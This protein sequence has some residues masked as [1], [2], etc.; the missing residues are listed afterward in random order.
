MKQI[1]ALKLINW[2]KISNETILFP[3]NM[4][5]T[6][7]NG[8]GKS[9]IIDALSIV[10]T[11][12]PK[13]FNL[14]ANKND[15]RNINSYVRCYT[16]GENYHSALR[17]NGRI[18]SHIALEFKNAD[19][20]LSVTGVI[21]TSESNS[22]NEKIEPKWYYC[23]NCSLSD[24]EFLKNGIPQDHRSL[25]AK[26]NVVKTM[27]TQKNA[28]RVFAKAYGFSG[29]VDEFNVE[30]FT[31]F[32]SILKNVIAAN[33]HNFKNVGDIISNCVLKPKNID[34]EEERKNYD[35]INE[36]K[37]RLD[38][39]EKKLNDLGEMEELHNKIE[40]YS[41]E[42][43]NYENAKIITQCN[44]NKNEIIKNKNNIKINEDKKC[45]YEKRFEI[46]E[47]EIESL[48]KR[49]EE[50]VARGKDSIIDNLKNQISSITEKIN[51]YKKE[52][53]KIDKSLEVFKMLCEAINESSFTKI[54]N[55]YL[56]D[57][58]S[59]NAESSSK[60]KEEIHK[61]ILNIKNLRNSIIKKTI[62]SKNV[63]AEIN[64][65]IRNCEIALSALRV[66]QNPYT[67]KVK[68]IQKFL[69]KE[70][71]SKGIND[72][73]QILCEVMDFTENSDAWI[74][75]IEGFMGNKRFA[76][77]CSPKNFSVVNNLYRQLCKENVS[78]KNSGIE[79][80]DMRQFVYDE[81]KEFGENMMIGHLITPN[82][83]V[84]RYLQYA[85]GNVELVEDFRN[86]KKGSRAI[87]KDCMRYVG[88]AT[89]YINTNNYKHKY[90]GNKSRQ[91]EIKKYTEELTCLKTEKNNIMSDIS[92]LNNISQYFDDHDLSDMV[93]CF[94]SN[95]SD[96]IDLIV[97]NKENNQ[98][99]V[100]LN[101]SLNEREKAL[102]I[103]SLA[104]EQREIEENIRKSTKEKD[105]ISNKI[106]NIDSKIENF[107]DIV[108]KLEE[109]QKEYDKSLMILEEE[110]YDAY[111]GAV[112]L[113]EEKY[114]HI[115]NIAEI[116][117]SITDKITR[118]DKN[119][120]NLNGRLMSKQN[121]FVEK[122]DVAF[123]TS[124]NS[125]SQQYI[126]YY[127]NIKNGKLIELNEKLSSAQETFKNN[128]YKNVLSCL[129]ESFI[130]VPTF[131]KRMNINL[132]YSSSE[133]ATI[134]KFVC[135]KTTD[136]EKREIYDLIM[137]CDLS[138]IE[139]LDECEKDVIDNLIKNLVNAGNED[140]LNDFADYRNYFE[141][142]VEIIKNGTTKR[143]SATCRTSSG[144][145]LKVPYY[146]IMGAALSN[147]YSSFDAENCIR[148][149]IA[150]EAFSTMDEAKTL[151]VIQILK[152][153]G[154]QTIFAAPLDSNVATKIGRH[155]N[156]IIATVDKPEYRYTH[157]FTYEQLVDAIKESNLEIAA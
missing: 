133:D 13:K 27:N 111:I 59:C 24:I 77:F 28:M 98:K 154:F 93:D 60:K 150:D 128:F 131:F 91:S 137:N 107:E 12:E 143:L 18:T 140:E 14:A 73:V 31:N 145:E 72:E 67:N 92:K 20:S 116:K 71:K 95:Y 102:N 3:H 45:E 120:N 148:M 17:K 132:K 6:G 25:K 155:V 19:D 139:E 66:N 61:I 87:T 43:I 134:Y 90:I 144:G 113:C 82:I 29:T 75:A 149:F 138:D 157:T 50:L 126:D 101:N 11:C 55:Y 117:N 22:P 70:L 56:K 48:Y 141:Y 41:S 123:G 46:L 103:I 21:F 62:E 88:C 110:S 4:L 142:D 89:S 68:D 2:H 64:S 104:N 30:I 121:I 115:N 51:K 96:F 10:L 112:K 99:L 105:A 109:N 33:V 32:R 124:G 79:I 74:N 114:S 42:K 81:I 37:S 8:S 80:I 118:L 78:Y 23:E 54:N 147:L 127:Y 119:I 53:I 76:L 16:E 15:K 69:N 9:T 83:N 52:K 49:K 130:D 38:I 58:Y 57:F 26:G 39:Y 86:M 35:E 135:T 63:L 85:F 146:I 106:G 36:M 136:I 34:I 129:K 94:S 122:Y 7:A 40:N 84:R 152:N 100:L 97:Q 1:T 5:L 125:D 44:F 47:S 156:G 151:S 108:Y 65:E 153:F